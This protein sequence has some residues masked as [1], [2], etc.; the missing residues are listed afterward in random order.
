MKERRKARR[1]RL[2]YIRGGVL[3][4]EGREHVVAVT[5]LSPEGAFLKTQAPAELGQALCLRM[6]LPREG[7]EM[8]LPCVVVRRSE[9]FD[10]ATGQ[11]AGLAV[12]FQALDAGVVRRVEEF[13]REGFLPASEPTPHEHVEYRILERSELSEAELNQLGLDGWELS[14]ALPVLTGVRLILLRRL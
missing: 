2:P 5:D 6:V 4:V 8:P 13:A 3:E 1:R 12:R 11:P 7:R 14:A 9:H 10:P